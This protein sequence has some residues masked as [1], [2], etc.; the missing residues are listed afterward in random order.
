MFGVTQQY[1]GQL[2][3]KHRYRS[4]FCSEAAKERQEHFSVLVSAGIAPD[5]AWGISGT[6]GRV[7]HRAKALERA[8][9]KAARLAPLIERVRNGESL[10]SV[11]EGDRAL[12]EKLRRHCLKV[13]IRS[14][15]ESANPN[16]K[17]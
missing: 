1:I 16:L 8:S 10:R 17:K 11:A 2:A 15:F 3:R 7:V 5:T 14:Q 6:S 4:R 12:S 13:G 9:N